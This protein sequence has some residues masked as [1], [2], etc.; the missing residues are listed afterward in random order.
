M[1]IN[2]S[3]NDLIFIV[4]DWAIFMGNF[5]AVWYKTCYLGSKSFYCSDPTAGFLQVGVQGFIWSSFNLI[6]QLTQFEA[7]FMVQ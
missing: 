4:V 2:V 3:P 7:H 1:N 5:D 6:A